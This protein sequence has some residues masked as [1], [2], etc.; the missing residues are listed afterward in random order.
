[1]S[2][3]AVVSPHSSYAI[4]QSTVMSGYGKGIVAMWTRVAAVLASVIALVWKRGRTID[5][6]DV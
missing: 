3:L 4:L 1:M 2:Y 5:H 6:V